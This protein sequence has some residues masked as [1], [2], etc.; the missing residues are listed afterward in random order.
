MRIIFA[1]ASRP[2]CHTP[3]PDAAGSGA[4][5]GSQQVCSFAIIVV[6][7]FWSTVQGTRSPPPTLTIPAAPNI[8]YLKSFKSIDTPMAW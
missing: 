4:G 8:S 1:M 6:L 7:G 3:L 2:D 5:T